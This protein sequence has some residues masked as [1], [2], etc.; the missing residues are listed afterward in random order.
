MGLPCGALA[1]N[2]MKRTVT[3]ERNYLILVSYTKILD[4]LR[5]ELNRQPFIAR[6]SKLSRWATREA[7]G[8]PIGW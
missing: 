6:E 4:G 1:G 2:L 7:G 5:Q 8:M 3:K